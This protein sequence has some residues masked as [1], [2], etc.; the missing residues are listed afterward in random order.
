MNFGTSQEFTIQAHR[1]PL[2][3][4]GVWGR[5]SIHVQG[6]TLGQID[7]FGALY[8]PAD[9]FRDLHDVVDNLWDQL[10]AHK[11]DAEIFTV[12]N[13]ALWNDSDDSLQVAEQAWARFH[14]FIFLSNWGEQFDGVKAFIIRPP[15]HPIRILYASEGAISIALCSPEAIIEALSSF[16][17]WFD[18]ETAIS[19]PADI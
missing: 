13:N 14:R 11:S 12:L 15:G 4:P 16:L 17:K 18:A 5:I 3:H 6:A 9:F 8:V 2:N 19:L 1:E 7:K 10:F